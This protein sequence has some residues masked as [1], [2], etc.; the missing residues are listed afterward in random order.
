MTDGPARV[1]P[2]VAVADG[3]LK[4]PTTL[5]VDSWTVKL[6]PA[7]EPAVGVNFRPAAPWARVMKLPLVI[8]VVPLFW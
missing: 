4:P 8:G 7:S 2:I 3:P 1:T 6:P 5:V